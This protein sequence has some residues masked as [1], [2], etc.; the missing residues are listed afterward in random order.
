MPKNNF[1]SHRLLLLL[2]LPFSLFWISC[3]ENT[4]STLPIFGPKEFIEGI[5]KDTVYHTIP[6]WS[7]VNQDGITVSKTDY[8]DTVYVAYYFF[9][10][11]PTICPA[12]TKQVKRLQ[13]ETKGLPIKFIAHTV[14]P[15]NDHPDRL[16]YYANEYQFDFS[17][18]NFVTGDKNSLY[19]LG[20]EGYMIPSQE[21]ALAPGGFLHSE[22]LVL[23]DKKARIRG[24]YD[25][26][27]ED[28][29]NQLKKD[30]S[31]L[32]NE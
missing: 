7:F 18:I 29:V 2:V 4:S 22:M 30:I 31:I 17:N 9:T 15:Q 28:Q 27:E 13:D 12:M 8:L 32:I 24:Y 3:S 11:C 16:K 21:D 1:F 23:I 14:D 10:H 19:T 20:V 26:S 6:F 5:D 25:G